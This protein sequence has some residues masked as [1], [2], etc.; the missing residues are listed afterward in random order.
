V[1][2]YANCVLEVFQK[3]ALAK[4]DIILLGHSFGGRVAIELASKNEYKKLILIGS[5][6]VDQKIST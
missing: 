5:S 3:L 6:G 2:E 1:P 4:S